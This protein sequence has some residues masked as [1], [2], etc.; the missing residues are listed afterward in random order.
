MDTTT[1][2]STNR[3]TELLSLGKEH[4]GRLQMGV[5]AQNKYTEQK[6]REVI[7]S[8]ENHCCNKLHVEMFRNTYLSYQGAARVGLFHEGGQ[9]RSEG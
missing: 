2:N 5:W 4:A 8:G 9:A 3:C 1:Q 6:V 7:Y